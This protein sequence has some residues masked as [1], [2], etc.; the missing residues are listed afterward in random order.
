MW[1]GSF[2]LW[3]WDPFICLGAL[4]CL[5]SH[6]PC[7]F[8]LSNGFPRHLRVKSNFSSPLQNFFNLLLLSLSPYFILLSLAHSSLAVS[9]CCCCCCCFLNVSSL[10]SPK[11]LQTYSP[12]H[13]FPW[14]SL[15]QY[16]V[17]TQIPSEKHSLAMWAKIPESRYCVLPNCSSLKD[18][19]PVL[20]LCL[21]VICPPWGINLTGEGTMCILF[22]CSSSEPIMG[23]NTVRSASIR[24]LLWWLSGKES[25]YQ[26][27]RL[28]F[29][30]WFRKIPHATEQLSPCTTTDW[31]CA[32][33]SGNWSYW[34]HVPQSPCSTR[35]ATARRSLCT[36]TGE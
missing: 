30:P 31:A 18:S 20:F 5:W 22:S 17:V 8:K 36:A 13:S 25:T 29:D 4:V 28:M 14:R 33:E 7:W 35:G 3:R 21:V 16:L 19:H 11:A 15:I 9:V 6:D 10:V 32:P 2:F 1:T 34:A 24:G 23:P 26:C 12:E 27:R